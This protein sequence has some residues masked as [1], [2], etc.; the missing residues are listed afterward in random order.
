MAKLITSATPTSGRQ[1]LVPV[2]KY[3]A[4]K[5]VRTKF[6]IVLTQQQKEIRGQL[7]ALALLSSRGGGTPGP[8]G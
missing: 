2:L 4:M 1:K 8:I 6:H 7:H 5:G 3:C